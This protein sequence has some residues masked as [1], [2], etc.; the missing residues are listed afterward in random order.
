MWWSI[1]LSKVTPWIGVHWI[2]HH[3]HSQQGRGGTQ[4]YSASSVRRFIVHFRSSDPFLKL[5][6]FG[7]LRCDCGVMLDWFLHV[8]FHF[9]LFLFFVFLAGFVARGCQ[10]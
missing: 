5:G 6:K 8:V 10:R 7:Q 2:T 9:V 3:R 1:G 4:F